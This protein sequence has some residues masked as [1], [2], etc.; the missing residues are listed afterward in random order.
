MIDESCIVPSDAGVNVAITAEM[1]QKRVRIVDF[2]VGVALCD[3]RV[4][5][6]LPQVS[7]QNPARANSSR[8]EDPEAVNL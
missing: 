4:G 7:D 5:E 6:G 2:V 8:R 1:E 3:F